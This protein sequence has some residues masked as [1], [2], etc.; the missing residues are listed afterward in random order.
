MGGGS[1]ASSLG[2]ARGAAVVGGVP[3]PVRTLSL[4]LVVA[5]TISTAMVASVTLFNVRE[6]S[7]PALTY[8][9]FRLSA[10]ALFL[11][12]G[13]LR[14]RRW[15]L[16]LDRT[17]ALMSAA[18]VVLGVLSLPLNNLAGQIV[19]TGA[20]SG[21]SL[22]THALGSL[23]AL[24]LVHRGLTVDGTGER[25][26]GQRFGLGSL[27]RPAC[28][29][30]AAVLAVTLLSTDRGRSAGT[31]GVEL[32][33]A[34]AWWHKGFLAA[35]RDATQPWAGRVAPLLGS[36]G[37]V[38][39]LRA[40]DTLQP[41]TWSLPGAAL[42]ASVAITAL[43]SA[44][45]D[46]SEVAL[47]PVPAT[48]PPAGSQ[49]R[50]ARRADRRLAS[51]LPGLR[52]RE[53]RDLGRD[54]PRTP[55]TR[56]SG[57]AAAAAPR[58]AVPRTSPRCSS[59][60]LSN[61]QRYAPRSPVTLQMVEIAGRIEISVSDL[62]PGMSAADAYRALDD[63]APDALT[64]LRAARALL[65]SSG[66][67]LELRNRIGGTTFVSVLPAA[68]QPAVPASHRAGWAVSTASALALGDLLGGRRQ[69]GV[70]VAH[71]TEVDEL[72]D[73][74]LLVLVD[75]DD[76]LRGLHAGPVLD[77]A[78]DAVRDVQLRRDRLAGLADLERVRH[79][80]GVD[81]G[82][83]GADGRAERVGEALD[84]SKLPPVPRPPETTIA[85]SVSSGRPE[86][87]RGSDAVIRAAFAAS[88]MVAA[89]VLL[90]RRRRR[91]PPASW[92]SA[93]R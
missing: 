56:R 86:A 44:Y 85:A 42:L 3:V 29:L 16:T 23:L 51:R 66:G 31:V 73:R 87:L 76:G 65:E 64:G 34:L 18:F 7:T 77:R 2:R 43:H 81:G 57:S 75:R 5:V 8:D 39:I 14:L 82:A 93:S 41:G 35:R 58:T 26:A 38:E 78:G 15:K 6:V 67:R 22:L 17:S 80:A 84:G 50:P 90:R 61:A 46:L 10:A 27:A 1:A 55:Q 40:A 92:S 47:R 54:E 59:E 72:E 19:T 49:R 24:W 32:M 53:R 30:A 52:R 20:E 28:V 9:A 48:G 12:A 4:Q 33:I 45:V 21:M 83:R 89:N 88:E 74:R 11:A 13:L 91:P 70:Q 68:R 25:A 62:G 60:L 63:P 37:A 79:P 36:L 69:H 71:D